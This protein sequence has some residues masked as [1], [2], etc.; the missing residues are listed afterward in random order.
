MTVR[1]I[2]EHKGH[3]VATVRP[4]AEIEEAVSLFHAKHI[5]ALVVS[6]DGEEVAGIISERDIVGALAQWGA[7][8]WHMKVATVMSRPVVTCR[9]QDGIADLMILMTER[10]IRHL[11]VVEE[12]RL[13][14]IVSIGDVVKHR[15]EEVESEAN[16]I[17]EFIHSA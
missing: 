10:R 13:I 12:G 2:L 8:I 7:E 3:E 15:I 5:G 9:E 16:T 4:D 6:A 11:P 1:R 14:G 17:R